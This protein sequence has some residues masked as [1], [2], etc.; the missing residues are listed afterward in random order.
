MISGVTENCAPKEREV[1]LIEQGESVDGKM[2][3]ADVNSA[4]LQMLSYKE[5]LSTEYSLYGMQI[6]VSSRFGCEPWLHTLPDVRL[7]AHQ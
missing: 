5:V 4:A 3:I 6:P 1:L 2:K 7:W